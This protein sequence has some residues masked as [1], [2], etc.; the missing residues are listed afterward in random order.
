M[1]YIFVPGNSPLNKKWTYDLKEEFQE[2]YD[3]SSVIEFDHWKTGEELA[4]VD[5]EAKKL[6]D[7]ISEL[8]E[9]YCIVAKSIGTL[10]SSLAIKSSIEKPEKVF[11]IGVPLKW[12]AQNAEN[13]ELNKSTSEIYALD[14]VSKV[15]V[16]KTKDFVASAKEVAAFININVSNST[17]V[18]LPGDDHHYADLNSLKY[19]WK[20]S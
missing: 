16:Q 17:F 6:K 20:N 11:F 4:N 18:E 2:F 13:L 19:I 5:L 12:V 8:E 7:L 15:F 14:N 9:P 1:H 10:I 3:S